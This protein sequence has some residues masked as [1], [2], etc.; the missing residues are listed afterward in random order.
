[1]WGEER[2]ATVAQVL[3]VQ[4][5]PTSD[6]YL[7]ESDAL[8]SLQGSCFWRH[9]ASE[10]LPLQK[11]SSTQT[12]ARSH[13]ILTTSRARYC[14]PEHQA[15]D[16]KLHRDLCKTWSAERANKGTAS[17]ESPLLPSAGAADTASTSSTLKFEYQVSIGGSDGTEKYVFHHEAPRE[18][19]YNKTAAGQLLAQLIQAH[20]VEVD[21]V[22][23]AKFHNLSITPSE[24]PQQPET[25]EGLLP[26]WRDGATAHAQSSLV[27]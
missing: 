8:L 3:L 18:A 7:T 15:S 16:W 26:V 1:M 14:S 19:A 22:S 20:L 5:P 24:A 6:D 2:A 13:R 27:P 17:A 21:R 4:R 10:M 11:V 25:F 9:F 12:P 23:T